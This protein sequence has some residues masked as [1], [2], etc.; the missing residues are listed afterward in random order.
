MN[1]FKRK[2]AAIQDYINF[3]GIV[4]FVFVIVTKVT[5]IGTIE[6]MFVEENI[7]I[8]TC[9]G[10]LLEMLIVNTSLYITDFKDWRYDIKERGIKY[11]GDEHEGE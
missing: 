7:L 6:T 1:L 5:L 10:V 3:A 11:K 9:L 4:L 8:L 2:K